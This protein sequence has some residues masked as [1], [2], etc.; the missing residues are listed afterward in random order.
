MKAGRLPVS[1]SVW[2]NNSPSL[3]LF[4]ALNINLKPVNYAY[5]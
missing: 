4:Y 2:W 3:C 5:T 1:S